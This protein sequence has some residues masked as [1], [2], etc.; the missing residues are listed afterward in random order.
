MN[1][2]Q[3]GDAFLK[4]NAFLET[5]NNMHLRLAYGEVRIESRYSEIAPSDAR[6]DSLFSENVPVRVPIVSAAM[7]TVTEANMAI[8]MA[9][10]GGIGTVHKAMSPKDQAKIIGRVKH[11]QNGRIDDPV[12]MRIDDTVNNLYELKRTK[13]YK[14][15]RFLIVDEHR[16]LRGLVSHRDLDFCSDRSQ[17]LAEIMTPL[18]HLTVAP[19]EI[20]RE[21]SY[22]VMRERKVES[23]PLLDEHGHPVGLFLLE[24]LK[25]MFEGAST[26]NV[27]AN[28]QLRVA[29]AVGVGDEE[30][31]RVGLL[32]KQRCDALVI[33]TAHGNSVRVL[34][35]IDAIRTT[36][37]HSRHHVADI[38]PGNVSNGDGALALAKAGANGIKVG[39]GPGSICTTRLVAGIGAPQASAVGNCARALRENGFGH[40]PL[41]ADGGIVNSGDIVVA[42]ALGAASVM[43]GNLLAGTDEAPGDRIPDGVHFVKKYRGMGSIEAMRDSAASRQRYGQENVPTHKLV[44]EGVPSQVPYKGPVNAILDQ[45]AGGVRQGMGYLGAQTIVEM[46]TFVE[47]FWETGAGMR[48]SAPHD[49]RVINSM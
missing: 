43:C 28:D 36:Y 38:I 35:M 1:S 41:C 37:S 21:D 46:P 12:T 49:V 29:A 3:N 27:D 19:A 11:F 40:I 31:E 42:F 10:Y 15:H 7:D 33:D 23:L 47:P 8:A 22:R 5:T 44:A 34:R 13:G 32:L 30:L 25:R 14:F 2:N 24:D 4:L 16:K 18:D 48:E 6:L 17:K 39:Q 45:L 9:L 20:T 26:A